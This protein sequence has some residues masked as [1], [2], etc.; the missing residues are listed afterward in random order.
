M[1]L[2]VLPTFKPLLETHIKGWGKCERCQIGS[3]AHNHVFYRGS[4]PADILFVGLAPGKSED[5]LGFPFVGKSGMLVNRWIEQSLA[6]EV[7]YCFAN[8]VACRPCDKPGSPNRDPSEEEIM[9]CRPRL[10]GMIRIFSFKAV[11]TIGKIA[12][13]YLPDLSSSIPN[14]AIRHPSYAL[15]LGA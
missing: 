8:L 2:D 5:A 4:L 15:R 1:T 14:L 12:A 3:I 11:V 9:N 7:P 10:T 13:E 6:E